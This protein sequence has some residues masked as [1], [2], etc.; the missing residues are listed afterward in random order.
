[1]RLKL[2]GR[3]E[4]TQTASPAPEKVR[5]RVRLRRR[6]RAR[7]LAQKGWCAHCEVRPR[8]DARGNAGR[9]CGPEC[10]DADALD[11]WSIA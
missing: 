10:A 5:L 9:F 11:N 1:M 7:V 6:W 3:A 4:R 2:V 8:A